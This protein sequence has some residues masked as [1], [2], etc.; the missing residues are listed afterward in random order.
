MTRNL[1]QMIDDYAEALAQ[2]YIA[3]NTNCPK[4]RI[5]YLKNK[6]WLKAWDLRHLGLNV[7]PNESEND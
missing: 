3:E 5:A 1:P 4:D 6:M 7:R 2:Y